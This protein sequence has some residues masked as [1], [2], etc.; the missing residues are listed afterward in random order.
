MTLIVIKL[1]EI[2]TLGFKVYDNIDLFC[3]IDS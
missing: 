3:M 2:E 1:F